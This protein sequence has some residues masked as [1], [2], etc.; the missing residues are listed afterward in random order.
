[1]PYASGFPVLHRRNVGLRVPGPSPNGSTHAALRRTCCLIGIRTRR[2]STLAH[3]L[4]RPTTIGSPENDWIRQWAGGG[5]CN[6]YPP[7]LADDRHLDATVVFG[8]Q[9]AVRPSSTGPA[10][11]SSDQRVAV[12]HL[13]S[14]LQAAPLQGRRSGYVGTHGRPGR[15]GQ[16]RG[17][18][19][20]DGGSRLAVGAPAERNDVGALHA[21]PAL[22]TSGADAAQLSGKLSVSIRFWREGGCLSGGNHRQTAQ[23]RHPHRSR[24]QERLPHRQASGA[25]GVSRRHRPSGIRSAAHVQTHLHLY[26]EKRPRLQIHGFFAQQERN[27][28]PQENHGKI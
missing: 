8:P 18:V 4:P 9:P 23:G 13:A 27:A 16:F 25:H 24:R 3:D 10:C 26:S 1:M 11:R 2:A 15:Q 12:V 14:H 22:D 5:I 20:Q 6:A 17:A 21:L 7:T 19:R 28:A